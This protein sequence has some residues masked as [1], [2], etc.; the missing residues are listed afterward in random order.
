MYLN[1]ERHG[2]IKLCY[3]F[4]LYLIFFIEN[5]LE[6]VIRYKYVLYNIDDII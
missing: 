5:S 1:N 3:S 6:K 4:I 2:K